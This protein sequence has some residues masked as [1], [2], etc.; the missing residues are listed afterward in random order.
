MRAKINLEGQC[1][2]TTRLSDNIRMHALNHLQVLL[3]DFIDLG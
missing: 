2:L 1:D 3:S